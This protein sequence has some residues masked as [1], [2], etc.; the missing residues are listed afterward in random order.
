MSMIPKKNRLRDVFEMPKE[1]TRKMFHDR[2]VS[3]PVPALSDLKRELIASI[4]EERSKVS[5]NF[6]TKREPSLQKEFCRQ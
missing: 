5:F 3:I 6:V 4:G 1:Q 2:M